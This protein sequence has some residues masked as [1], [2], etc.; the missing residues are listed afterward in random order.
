MSV[1]AS[2]DA[3]TSN[4]RR[5]ASRALWRRRESNPRPSLNEKSDGARLP[6]PRLDSPPN[7]LPLRVPWS[8]LQS[9]RNVG[10]GADSRLPVLLS[11]LKDHLEVARSRPTLP[12]PAAEAYSGFS[13]H[14]EQTVSTEDVQGVERLA[15]YLTRG[16]LPIDVVEKV[17]GGRLRVRTLPAA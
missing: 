1:S 13:V 16:P 8:P 5:E 3:S 2:A 15:R 9:W 7:P 14:G 17:E 10:D 4:P 12:P 6:L 11:A